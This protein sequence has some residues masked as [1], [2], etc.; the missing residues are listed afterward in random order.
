MQRIRE[1]LKTRFR[2][3]VTQR[4]GLDEMAVD[5]LATSTKLQSWEAVQIPERLRFSSRLAI[6]L[7][8]FFM[9]IV[10]FVPWTQTITVTGQLSAYTPFERPQDTHFEAHFRSARRLFP[11]YAFV[12]TQRASANICYII[13]FWRWRGPGGDSEAKSKFQCRVKTPFPLI[14]R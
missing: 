6:L 9:L 4:T 2:S 7:V 13:C 11:L 3:L 14:G 8:G 12:W 10:T 1:G 5:D